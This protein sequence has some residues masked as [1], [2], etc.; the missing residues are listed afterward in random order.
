MTTTLARETITPPPYRG[1][2]Q[3]RK[4]RPDIEGLRAIAV[5]FVV[6]SHSGLALPGGYVGVDV[7]FVISGFLITR[8]LAGE[9]ERRNRISFTGFYARRARRILPAATV[10]IVATLLADWKWDSPLRV[11]SIATDGLFSAFSGIN[12]RLAA[13]GT[14]YFAA[15]TPPSPFQHYWSLGVEEQFY[16]IWP[17][18]LMGVGLL[19]GG[20]FGR[21]KSL[22]WALGVIMAA[23]LYLSIATTSSSPSWA[24]FGLHTRAWELALGSLLALTVTVWTRMPPALA[25]Q[26]SWLGIVMIAIAG[27]AY[28]NGTVYPG[29]AVVL[30]VLGSAFVIAGGCPGWPRGAEMSL[31]L[32]PMQYIGKLSYSWYLWHWPVLMILPLALGHDLTTL[33]TWLA[34]VGS[35][36]AAMAAFYLVEQP[37]RTRQVFRL[38]LRGLVLGGAL[39]ATSVIVALVVTSSAVIP[40]GGPATAITN[41]PATVTAIQKAIL[42]GLA[43]KRL[44]SNITPSLQKAP[45]DHPNT[46]GCLLNA[47]IATVPPDSQCTFGDPNGTKTIAVVGDSHANAWYPAINAFADKYHWRFILYAK[48][49]CPPGVY[50]NYIN[51]LTHRVYTECDEWRNAMFDRLKTTKPDVVLVTSQ[52]RTLSVDP[53]GMVQAI[54]NFKSTGARVLYLEDTPYPGT[55]DG[56]V[57]DCLAKNASDIQKCSLSR[58]DPRTRL[59]NMIQRTTESAAAKKAGATLIDPTSWFCSATLCP[60]V[61]NNIVVYSDDSHITGTYNLWLAPEM[62]KTLKKIIG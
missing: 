49:A 16:V 55:V 40:G 7:F 30:P 60:T 11:K 47:Q 44:P 12:W 51:P 8:Q 2:R 1:P 59:G 36:V 32:P 39:I 17:A 27:L 18:L 35:F 29:V 33:D 10:V 57:P 45:L 26:M 22:V 38:P 5:L 25:S 41:K 42:A 20:R 31:R 61:I 4:F 28:G 43:L 37:I 62:T 21:R 9:F 52:I 24:Y 50:T 53:A 48:A 54:E 6:F 34:V 13:Q 58:T 15:T 19:I 3:V 46:H 56:L 14:D 23:S